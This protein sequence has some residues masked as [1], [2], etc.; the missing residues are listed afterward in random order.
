MPGAFAHITAVNVAAA[1]TALRQLD[2]PRHAKKVLSQYKKYL[3]LGCVSPDYPYLA[4]L[5]GPQNQWR[6]KCTTTTSV[7]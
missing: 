6:M 4:I 5:N 3:E 7:S 2:I 1:N